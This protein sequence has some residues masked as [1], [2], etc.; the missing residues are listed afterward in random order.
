MDAVWSDLKWGLDYHMQVANFGLSITWPHN[1]ILSGHLFQLN[2]LTKKKSDFQTMYWYNEKY[3]TSRHIKYIY[4]QYIVC[5]NFSKLLGWA[6]HAGA[7]SFG[8]GPMKWQRQWCHCSSVASI[9]DGWSNPSPCCIPAMPY[10]ISWGFLSFS[11]K[12]MC[13]YIT[14]KTQETKGKYLVKKD[15][16]KGRR[17]CLYWV[18]LTIQQ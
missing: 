12:M 10:R 18:W 11:S 13:F 7:Y 4:I 2:Y 1:S 15:A 3:S 8:N 9:R 5:L 16:V 6:R 17:G 14:S